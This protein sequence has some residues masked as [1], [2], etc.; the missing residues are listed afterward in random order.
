MS[1][2]VKPKGAPVA[3]LDEALRLV[4]NAAFGIRVK[5][6]WVGKD[7]RLNRAL[8]LATLYGAL[9]KH[10]DFDAITKEADE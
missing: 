7:A 8:E 9:G 10:Y 2:K 1:E 5:F 4:Y 3:E 6:R